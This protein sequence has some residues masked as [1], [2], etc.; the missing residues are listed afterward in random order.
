[1]RLSAAQP[2]NQFCLMIPSSLIGLVAGISR[3]PSADHCSITTMSRLNPTIS[4]QYHSSCLCF[5]SYDME[6]DPSHICYTLPN[7]NP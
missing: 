1:M 7:P 5:K 4:D 6:V 2:F 3:F